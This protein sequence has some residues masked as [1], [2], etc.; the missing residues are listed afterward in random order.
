M[1]RNKLHGRLAPRIVRTII[2]QPLQHGGD[3]V[4]SL[5]LLETVIVGLIYAFTDNFD[6]QDL[7]AESIHEGVK[8][9]LAD[10]R[11]KEVEPA[12]TA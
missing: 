8:A 12:G 9:R 2:K 5:V 11:L 3:R 7:L 1:D 4:D 10:I 6:R